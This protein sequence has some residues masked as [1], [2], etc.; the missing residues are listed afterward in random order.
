[1]VK[2]AEA[3]VLEDSRLLEQTK[4]EKLSLHAS[5]KTSRNLIL[6]TSAN[7]FNMF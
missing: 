1:M 5:I 3:T 6:T 2:E 7:Y 4:R